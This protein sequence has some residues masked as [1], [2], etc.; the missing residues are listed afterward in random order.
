METSQSWVKH[1]METEEEDILCL[2]I[3]KFTFKLALHS[4]SDRSSSDLYWLVSGMACLSNG[5]V[6]VEEFYRFHRFWYDTDFYLLQKRL[7]KSNITES[8]I[9]PGCKC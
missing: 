6:T 3:E 9:S 7:Q 5:V 8:G 1:Y 4:W 2:V